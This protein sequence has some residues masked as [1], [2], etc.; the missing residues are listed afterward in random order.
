M[1]G[2]A[3]FSHDRKYR[4]KLWRQW[5]VSKQTIAFI[6]LNPSTANETDNDPTVWCCV[7][8]A[9]DWGFGTLHIGNLFAVCSADPRRLYEDDDPIGPENDDALF[10]M[11]ATAKKVVVAWGNHGVACGRGRQVMELLR[12]KGHLYCFGLNKTGEPRHPLYLPR[13]AMVS[14]VVLEPYEHRRM[15]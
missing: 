15:R 8:F 7:N 3:T 6:C 1:D 9:R 14:E 10:D 2:G 11:A 5:D 12:C 13:S 4:Y